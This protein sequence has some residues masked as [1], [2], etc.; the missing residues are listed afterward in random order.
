MLYYYRNTLQPT[1]GA[2]SYAFHMRF[3]LPAFT[4]FTPGVPVRWCW[5][6]SQGPQAYYAKRVP[7]A[8]YG[9]VS[10]GGIVGQQLSTNQLG[11]NQGSNLG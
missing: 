2:E 5:K 8:G 7:V 1:P 10:A 11:L 9:G 4:P 6:T 3:G